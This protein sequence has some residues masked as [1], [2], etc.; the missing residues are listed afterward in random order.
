MRYLIFGK[1]DCRFCDK[2]L[3]LLGN[4][5]VEYEYY[6]VTQDNNKTR[7]LDL[8]EAANVEV[9]TVPQIFIATNLVHIHIGGYK[10][11]KKLLEG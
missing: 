3:E 8:A 7:L 10:E 11:L 6:D 2:A 1:E 4:N 5:D 9:N